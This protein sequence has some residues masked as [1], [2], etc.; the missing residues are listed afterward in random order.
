MGAARQGIGRDD[1]FGNLR[2]PG[3]KVADICPAD[4]HPAIAGGK[5]AEFRLTAVVDPNRLGRTA[6]GLHGP[7]QINNATAAAVD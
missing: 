6:G 5:R 1:R 7:G 4:L 2:H 3:L